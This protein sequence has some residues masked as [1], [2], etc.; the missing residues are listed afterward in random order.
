MSSSASLSN[1]YSNA[2]PLLCL[3]PAPASYLEN[4]WCF[5]CH[6]CPH[7]Q[8]S[9][10]QPRQGR[11]SSA[12][13]ASGSKNTQ[14]VS[15]HSG[16]SDQHYDLVGHRL[17]AAQSVSGTWKWSFSHDTHSALALSGSGGYKR[18]NCTFY[19]LDPDSFSHPTHANGRAQRRGFNPFPWTLMIY[20]HDNSPLSRGLGE[21]CEL[22]SPEYI[23]PAVEDE[24]Q[25]F[26]EQKGMPGIPGSHQMLWRLAN[27]LSLTLCCAIACQ[28]G[29]QAE[30]EGQQTCPI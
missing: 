19:L 23:L 21:P 4:I 1:R 9:W 6:S 24:C 28:N 14:W 18:E 30:Q 22:V 7:L 16:Q 26:V 13:T 25:T 29:L 17:L 27:P 10:K 12:Y 2:S 20:C 3:I 15:G 8:S 5:L 11:C